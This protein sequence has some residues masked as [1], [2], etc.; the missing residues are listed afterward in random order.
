MI[1][2]VR[3]L[4]RQKNK[5]NKKLLVVKKLYSRSFFIILLFYSLVLSPSRIKPNNGTPINPDA[6]KVAIAACPT[7][8]ASPIINIPAP[9]YP[10]IFIHSRLGQSVDGSVV[11]T[12][13]GI[14]IG[15]K[16]NPFGFIVI[17]NL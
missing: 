8:A 16:C 14:N 12:Y 3:L 6:P 1:L 5:D 17:Y 13:T 15:G 11:Y 4:V 7:V 2:L 10:S 9:I